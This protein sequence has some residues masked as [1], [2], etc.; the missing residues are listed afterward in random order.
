MD[1]SGSQKFEIR[2]TRLSWFLD[3]YDKTYLNMSSAKDFEDDFHEGLQSQAFGYV[4]DVVVVD[5]KQ[6]V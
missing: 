5:V 1:S 4:H 6:K 3:I 2:P